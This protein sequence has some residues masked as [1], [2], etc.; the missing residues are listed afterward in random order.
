MLA[1][2]QAKQIGF[3]DALIHR[4]AT[5]FLFPGLGKSLKVL[6]RSD[7]LGSKFKHRPPLTATGRHRQTQYA[8]PTWHSY[9][10]QIRANLHQSLPST[11]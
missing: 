1:R 3:F 10:L 7:A 6:R 11:D 9:P 2:G 5:I 4:A 8:R